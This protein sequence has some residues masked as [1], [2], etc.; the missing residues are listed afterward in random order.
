MEIKQITMIS[1]AS[2]ATTN[3]NIVQK[4]PRARQQLLQLIETSILMMIVK[5]IYS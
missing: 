5:Y 4:I 3:F 2:T 1:T